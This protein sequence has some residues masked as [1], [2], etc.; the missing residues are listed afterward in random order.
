[1]VIQIAQKIRPTPFP[2]I[3]S[4]NT[5]CGDHQDDRADSHT[6]PGV[7]HVSLLRY[8]QI[9]VPCAGSVLINIDRLDDRLSVFTSRSARVGDGA[10]DGVAAR[11]DARNRKAEFR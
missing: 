10:Q 2:A 8:T 7:V 11:R 4:D 9:A 1:M 3:V 5:D 6:Q